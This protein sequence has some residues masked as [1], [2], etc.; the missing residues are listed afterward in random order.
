VGRRSL[1]EET[2]AGLKEE[3]AVVEEDGASADTLDRERQ[4]S[5]E[6][7]RATIVAARTRKA[8]RRR[9]NVQFYY[10]VRDASCR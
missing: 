9:V 1:A 7:K 6:I 4:M 3:E 8:N 5:K 10:A 2:L